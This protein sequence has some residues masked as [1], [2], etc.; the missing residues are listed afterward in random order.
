[1]SEEITTQVQGIK[2][3]L[4]VANAMMFYN[5]VTLASDL[6]GLIR[7]GYCVDAARVAALSSY[8]TKDLE[9]FGKYTMNLTNPP[10][11]VDYETPVVSPPAPPATPTMANEPLT[12]AG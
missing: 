10:E 5:T 4:L 1:M 3:T 2:Y 9:R 8:A 6:R 7:E 11:A 12:Q